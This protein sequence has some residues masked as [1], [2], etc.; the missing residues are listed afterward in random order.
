EDKI[1]L[2]A[3]EKE[4]LCREIRNE[5]LGYGPLEPL[6]ADPSINDILVNSYSKVFV[7]RRGKLEPSIIRFT[8]NAHLLKIIEKIASGVGRRIDESSPMVDARLPDGSRVN[9]IIP[10]LALDGPALSIRKFA[11]DPIKVEDLV[12]FG[13][14]TEDMAEVL[15]GMVQARLNILIS[16]GTGTG[17]TTFLNVLSSFI[18]NDERI[19][20]IED[21]AE[22]QLQQD[23]VVRLETRPANL[24]G[25][26]E[27]TQRDLVKNALRM[28][29]DRIILGEVR[30]GEALDM[31]QAMNTGHEGSMT[32]VHANSPRDALTRLENMVGMAG[33]NLPSK[34]TRQQISS[35]ITAVIHVSRLTDGKRKITSIQEITGMEGDIVTMQE[36]FIFEQTGVAPD[37]VV[38]GTFRATGIRPKFVDRLRTRGIK[39]SDDIFD[40]TRLYE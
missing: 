40:P 35:A 4:R 29:P 3:P 30:S 5:L 19:I 23:H 10:P 31:L 2:P 28:R 15:H 32:T 38:H 18:P 24:E 11:R 7:E 17:K 33:L 21:S 36:I 39:I 25:Q 34:A 12:G 16:G 1:P 27:V 6:L 22:L 26:G 9:A 20:T 13:A 37:G 14:I 8:D